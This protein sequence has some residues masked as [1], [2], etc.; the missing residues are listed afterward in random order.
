MKH[1]DNTPQWH[2]QFTMNPW[3]L[4]KLTFRAEDLLIPGL[5]SPSCLR[6]EALVQEQLSILKME[7]FPDF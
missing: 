7:Y 5:P 1:M 4:Q 3:D 2:Q 6:A